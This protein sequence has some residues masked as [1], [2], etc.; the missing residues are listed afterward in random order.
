M[1]KLQ[2]GQHEF[3]SALE[4]Y[5]AEGYAEDDIGLLQWY[6]G[7]IC[8]AL[9]RETA[10]IAAAT[11]YDASNI[12]RILRGKYEARLDNFLQ[13]LGALRADVQR[14]GAD[15]V[16]TVVTE[17]IWRKLDICYSRRYLGIICGKTGRSKTLT[18]RRWADN[19]N[20]GLTTYV[21][22]RSGCTRTKLIR[23]VAQAIGQAHVHNARSLMLEDGI[24]DWFNQRHR[25]MLILDEANHMLRHGT[26]TAISQAFEFVRDLYD[27]CNIAIVLVLT[28]Y[29]MSV[30]KFGGLADFFEQFRGRNQCYLEI[31]DRIYTEE[32]AQI[33]AAY[34][35]D[36]P[37]DLQKQA[38][39]IAVSRDG[40]LRTLFEYLNLAR[41]FAHKKDV[42]ITAQLLDRV[43]RRHE[44]GGAWPEA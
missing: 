33:C 32:I 34:V 25:K 2:V 18:V 44:A 31:P 39:T 36:P 23:L 3:L 29:D 8:N 6:W 14:T 42:P 5:R 16:E 28:D 4:R 11:R 13:V 30:F 38:M 35:P 10:K 21:R 37:E 9:G 26:K 41:E 40:K 43:R 22:C 24:F 17:E 1:G 7:Y 20:H 27:S 12:P 19:H 15:F